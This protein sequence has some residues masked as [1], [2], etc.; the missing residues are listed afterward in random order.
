MTVGR[1]NRNEL[2]F[3]RDGQ[4]AIART[5]IA[6]VGLGGVGSHLAQQLAY[7]GVERYVLIDDDIVTRSSLNRLIG[8]TPM[9]ADEHVLKVA[10]AKRMILQTRPESAVKVFP[11]TV[12]IERT[13]ALIKDVDVVFG[14]V[15]NERGRLELTELAMSRG[16]TYFD[17]A[18]DINP[19]VPMF[20]GRIFVAMPGVRCLSCAS[21]LDQ[22]EL[23]LSSMSPEHRLV[24]DKTYGI[25]RQDLG[26]GPSVVSI[27]GA[28]ASLAVTEFMA[29]V[30][31]LREPVEQLYYYG[32]SAVLRRRVDE[33]APSCPYCRPTTDASAAAS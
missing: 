9:D 28:V 16:I 21:G 18:T 8:A 25:P 15:D 24:H 10:V 2:L 11:E 26:G 17:L 29:W 20:G 1:S 22:A 5:G 4:S 13:G 23:R 31:D 27:N 32:H 3:G 14:C 19:D 12:D 33:V 6:I 7:L 30:T